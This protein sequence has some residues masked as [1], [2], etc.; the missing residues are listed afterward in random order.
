MIT[1]STVIDFLTFFPVID[2]THSQI[3]YQSVSDTFALIGLIVET[4]LK[5]YK[6]FG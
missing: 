1:N 4:T 3:L 5:I 2:E 6:I